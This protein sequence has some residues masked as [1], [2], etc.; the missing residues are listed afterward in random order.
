M[1]RFMLDRTAD[2]SGVSG[3]GLVAEGVT[4]VDGTTVIHW[5][6]A[7]TSTAVYTSM[8]TLIEIHGHEGATQVRWIDE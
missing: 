8:D 7:L 6:G 2:V 1:R 4:F 3:T 5:L